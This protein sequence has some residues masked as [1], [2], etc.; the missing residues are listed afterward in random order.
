MVS[1]LAGAHGESRAC[2]IKGGWVT[3]ISTTD[4]H[5]HRNMKVYTKT[6]D[7]GTSS[8]YNGERRHKTDG[9]F[10]ALGD[11]DELNSLCG[12]AREFLL[13]LDSERSDQV[14]CHW[15]TCY[16]RLAVSGLSPLSPLAAVA[17]HTIETA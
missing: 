1:A 12:V 8:L 13:P 2:L 4:G 6:G 7:K 11:V 17:K 5:I 9:A 16:S 14:N 10:Q 3:K 15:R